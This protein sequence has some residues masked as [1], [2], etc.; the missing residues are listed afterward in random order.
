MVTVSQPKLRAQTPRLEV[1]GATEGLSQGM[2][3]DL[4]QDQYGFIWFATRDGLNRFDGYSCEVFQNDPYNK[5]SISDNE[6]Q[7]ILEDRYGRIWIGT[8]NNGLD[9]FDPL[10]K[11]FYHLNSLPSQNIHC[12]SESPQGDVWVG[13]ANILCKVKL[14]APLPPDQ[15]DLAQAVQVE[16]IPEHLL[17][18]PPTGI[19]QDVFAGAGDR[20]WISSSSNI[21]YFEPAA[22]TYTPFYQFYNLP[23]GRQGSAFFRQG[24]DKSIWVGMPGQ[25]MNVRNNQ[26]A[27]IYKL[28]KESRYPKTD[29]AFDRHGNLF[30]STRKQIFK[31]KAGMIGKPASARF[32]L[33]HE[34][35]ATGIVGSTDIMFDRTGLFWIGTNGYGVIKHNPGNWVFEHYAQGRSPRR[36][37]AD[38]YGYAWVWFDGGFFRR[39]DTTNGAAEILLDSDKS[40][41]QHDATCTPDGAIWLIAEIRGRTTGDGVLIKLNGQTRNRELKLELPLTIGIFSRIYADGHH[42]LWIAGNKSNLARYDLQTGQFQLFNFSKTTGYQEATLSIHQDPNQQLWLGTPHGLVQAIPSGDSLRFILHKNDPQKQ[43]SLSNNYILSVL[44]DPQ[45]PARYCWIGTR[46]GGLNYLDKQT[47]LAKHYKTSDGLPNNVV[48]AVLSDEQKALWLSTN[49]GL[50]KFNPQQS[51][52]RNYF[53]VDGLQGNEFN[54]LS[55]AAGPDGRLYFGG[56]NGVS[57]F[58]PTSLVTTAITP[59]VWVTR[60]KINGETA[61]HIN[62]NNLDN[63]RISLNH[64]QNQLTFEFAA[65]DFAAPHLNQFQYRLWGADRDWTESTTNNSATYAHLS[66]GAYLFEVRTG[67]SR[68]IWDGPSAKL[69]IHIAPPWWGTNW[70]YLAYIA[71]IGLAVYGFF[72]F[73]LNKLRL[74]NELKFEQQEADR[75]AE[76]DKLKS[77]FFNS[78]AHEFRTPLTLLLEPA[79]QLLT[80]L[81]EKDVQYRLQLIEQNGERLLQYVNQLLDLAKLESGQMPL[82]LQNGNPAALLRELTEQFEPLATERNISIEMN[83]PDER[84]SGALDFD[85]WTKILSNL[86]SNALKFTQPGGRISI[87]LK[88]VSN[89][90]Q[91]NQLQL[92]VQDTGT[93]IPAEHLP[94]IFDRFYQVPGKPGQKSVGTGIGLALT[95][96]LVT[97]LG[98]VIQVES[99]VGQGALFTVTIPWMPSPAQPV[100]SSSLPDQPLWPAVQTM[101]EGHAVPPDDAAPLVL[102]VE[103]D[104]D[105]R[106]FLRASLPDTYRIAEAADGASGIE[107]ALELVPDLIIS[108]VAMP[109]KDGFELVEA[110]KNTPS[111]SHIPIIL[112]TAKAAF[113]SKIQGLSIGADIYL[114]KP[115]RSE[116]LNAHLQNLLNARNRWQAYFKHEPSKNILESAAKVL[117][118]RENEFI[119]RLTEVIDENLDNEAMDAEAYARAMFISRSQLHRKLT[120]LTGMALS[121]FVRNYRLDRAREILDSREISIADLAWHTGFP[122]T[123]YFSTSFKER[124]GVAPSEYRKEAS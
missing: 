85:K 9:I 11:R 61:G 33:F 122:D 52:F 79:R 20:I 77:S 91:T 74:E 54:T 105:L 101:P 42:A 4:L 14:P 28:P 6:V 31:L 75:L 32:E 53:N 7:A 37:F 71:L 97:L 45:N 82:H 81:K 90:D 66:P 60:L 12:L 87:G 23:N 94:K 44:D 72:R 109:L 95:Q 38:L 47:G 13:A 107:T 123:K 43:T 62:L 113:E 68:G 25:V 108:D 50:S 116:E 93:G 1:L 121:E 114:T 48:Y 86:L 19:I 55:Y 119:K 41:T 65:M 84:L 3:Y 70:A 78:V 83:C 26:I 34:F 51:V 16:A 106:R 99:P 21:G 57:A 29:M 100:P 111:T 117:S 56:V 2:I 118:T 67:G 102:L 18:I 89:P 8:A 15:P 73:Q 63:H 104:P 92:T 40:L 22:R 96:E 35:P 36:I 59:T 69:A 24:P 110:L 58:Y 64:D 80:K 76:L 120:A 46:G 88:V 49:C 115:F 27:G 39:M 10:S 103:D 124:F 98:G 5:F 112:L 30:V 17:P